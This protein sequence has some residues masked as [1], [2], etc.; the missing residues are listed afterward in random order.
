MNSWEE[1]ENQPEFGVL[2]P[3]DKKSL[4][5]AWKDNVLF[6]ALEADPDQIDSD[7]V[8]KFVATAEARSRSLAEGKPFDEA[9][10]LKDYQKSVAER[11]AAQNQ[12][13]ADYDEHQEA[14]FALRDAAANRGVTSAADRGMPLDPRV[15]QVLDRAGRKHNAD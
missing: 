13:L 14:L 10:A 9:T 11:T 7:G 12:V 1:I 3:E 15:A 5:D 2:N 8:H 6:A 4:H